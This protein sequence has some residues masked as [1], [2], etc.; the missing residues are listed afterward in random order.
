AEMAAYAPAPG[1]HVVVPDPTGLV[2]S[3][4]GLVPPAVRDAAW[5]ESVRA[6]WDRRPVTAGLGRM[7]ESSV[8]RFAPGS[9]DPAESLLPPRAAGGYR[10]FAITAE[11]AS[12][13]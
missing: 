8:A 12:S 4:D 2:S 1:L 10:P 9:P 7:T 3:R 13:D 5:R 6:A 11:T